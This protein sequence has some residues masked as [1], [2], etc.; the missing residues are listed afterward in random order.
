MTVKELI[1]KLETYDPEHLVMARI[2][3]K[4][5]TMTHSTPIIEFLSGHIVMITLEDC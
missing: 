1:E 2:N 3:H 5:E 4:N